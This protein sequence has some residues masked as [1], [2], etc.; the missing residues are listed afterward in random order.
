GVDLTLIKNQWEQKVNEVLY[1]ATLPTIDS[2]N[3][4]FMHTGG[5]TG[6]HTENLGYILTDLQ[7]LQRTYPGV[8]W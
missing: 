7:Y 6:T 5:K 4:T 3:K 8:E 1:E 2:T